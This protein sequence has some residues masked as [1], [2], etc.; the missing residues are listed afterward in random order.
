MVGEYWEFAVTLLTRNSP[1]TR[2]P[3]DPY[4][5]ALMLVLLESPPMPLASF[6]A[7]T[8]PPPSSPV[9]VG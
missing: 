8:N 4:I 2:L 9:M 7:I 6:H 5:W 1:P 3:S